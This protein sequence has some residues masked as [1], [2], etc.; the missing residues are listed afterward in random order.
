MPEASGSDGSGLSSLPAVALLCLARNPLGWDRRGAWREVDPWTTRERQ[1]SSR[2]YVDSSSEIFQPR[3]ALLM[4]SL[5]L[6]SSG[7]RAMGCD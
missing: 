4:T 6:S 5:K 3:W 2:L 7:M 1:R